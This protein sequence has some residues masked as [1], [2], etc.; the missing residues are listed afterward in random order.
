MGRLEGFTK[1][2]E[3][4][5]IKV[6]E[7]YNVEKL[8]EL[9]KIK[10]FSFLKTDEKKDKNNKYESQDIILE[11]IYKKLNKKDFFHKTLVQSN[12]G[13]SFGRYYYKK[14]T[15]HF[16]ILPLKNAV[17]G[18]ISPEGTKDLDIVNCHPTLLNHFMKK[19]NLVC[20]ELDEYVNNR[21]K[22]IEKKNFTKD[23]FL[24]MMYEK[25]FATE[26]KFLKNINN[27]IYTKLVPL[28]RGTY[29]KFY[30]ECSKKNNKNPD[31]SFLSFLLQEAEQDVM[32]YCMKY[33]KEKKIEYGCLIYDGIHI[34][35]NGLTD[36]NLQHLSDYIFNKCEYR[37]QFSIKDFPNQDLIKKELQEK[38]DNEVNENSEDDDDGENLTE[39]KI[40]EL[41]FEQKKNHL[42]NNNGIFYAYDNNEWNKNIDEILTLWLSECKINICIDKK[43]KKKLVKNRS[44]NW[45]NYK[46]HI[47]SLMIRELKNP[48]NILDIETG[49]LP[50]N[51]G[52]Y[53]MET[54]TFKEYSDDFIHYFSYKILRDYPKERPENLEFVKSVILE[55]FNNDEQALDE[56]FSFICRGLGKHTTDKLSLQLLGERDSGKGFILDCFSKSFIGVVGPLMSA[57]LN[58]KSTNES[59]ERQYS[60]LSTACENLVCVSQEI[61]SKLKF[62]GALWRTLVSGGDEVVYRSAYG[63]TTRKNIK[64][65]CIFASNDPI[66]FDQEE[67][68]STLI[69]YNMPCKFFDSYSMPD[70]TKEYGFVPKLKK[71][72]YKDLFK[73]KEYLDAFTVFLLEFYKSERP[74]YPTLFENAKEIYDVKD[75]K[76][77]DYSELSKKI[78]EL[79]CYNKN[80][81]IL[82]VELHKKL[83]EISS[84]FRPN[85]IFKI[86]SSKGV[87][88]AKNKGTRY[89]KG[90]SFKT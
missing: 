33:L 66:I 50:F 7:R 11:N 17:R 2:P 43:K 89:Y 37:V 60:F 73:Q 47:N 88:V 56:V 85:K 76:K 80:S 34:Y 19:E 52:L 44:C 5:E 40:A 4:E 25:D 31:G 59:A 81:M 8:E 14:N 86:L 70:V 20:P 9:L 48:V 13:K 27:M 12:E 28:L 61:K 77:E 65:L 64:A 10:D 16:G 82:C 83:D 45:E 72:D 36:D 22:V 71:P 29:G 42:I 32:Y 46:K 90:I 49:I 62:D 53:Y 58:P 79:I 38:K 41:F 6:V 69:L 21:K 87:I 35:N 30:D 3:I 67:S 57:E 23:K 74:I 55:I 15:G 51:N 84:S 63:R 78:D 54:K 18:Y 24:V 39:S 68:S 1:R 26:N 75:E